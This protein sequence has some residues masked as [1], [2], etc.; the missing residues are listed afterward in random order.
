MTNRYHDLN[1]YLRNMFG[2]RVQK[3]SLDAGLTC[4]NRDGRISTGGC[5][6]CNSRGSGT[7]AS[8]QGLSITEQI[9]RGKEFLKKRYKAQKFIAY[10]QSF[11]NTYGPYEKL[12]GLYQEALAIDD[13]VGLSIGTRPDCVDELVLTLLERYAKDYLVWIEYGL[14]SIHDRTLALID[15]G[16]DVGCFKGA[17]DKT[18]GRGIKICAHVILG[19]P[20]ED[21]HDMLATAKAV[22]A[23]G[24]DGIKIHLLYVV[25]G[26]RME[27]L[28]L[29]G[30]YRCLEQEEYVN[31]VCDFLELLPPDMVIQRL[32]GD[33]HP[34][35]LVAPE[36]SLRKNETLS[37]IKEILAERESWQGKGFNV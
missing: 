4:P 25:K 18:R 8:R 17:V 10:F 13:I 33:P 3:I 26:T 30:K 19:L 6:Y 22:A 32:T 21:R 5:M 14:Q 29:E 11:S 20:F 35:E 15:R 27:K 1:S 34:H 23:M 31:L 7:G 37:R 2:Y 28:Y 12:K 36:W 9:M 16:H 24:I